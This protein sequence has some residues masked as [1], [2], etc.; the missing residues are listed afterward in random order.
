[1]L[2]TK[3]ALPLCVPKGTYSSRGWQSDACGCRGLRDAV[4]PCAVMYKRCATWRCR[5]GSTECS[6]VPP[7]PNTRLSPE[8]VGS[9]KGWGRLIVFGDDFSSSHRCY[10]DYRDIIEFIFVARSHRLYSKK[11]PIVHIPTVRAAEVDIAPTESF[12]IHYPHRFRI[13][14]CVPTGMALL[15]FSSSRAAFLCYMAD[16]N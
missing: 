15:N 12:F 1:M 2:S 9:T 8:K 10:F 3:G 13:F 16:S 7:R 5:H 4:L 6:P 11:T 14:E